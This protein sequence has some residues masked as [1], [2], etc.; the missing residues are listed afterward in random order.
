MINEVLNVK[1][2]KD[3]MVCKKCYLLLLTLEWLLA[4]AYGWILI[5]SNLRISDLHLF[6]VYCIISINIF[7]ILFPTFLLLFLQSLFSSNSL[8]VCIVIFFFLL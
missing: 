1:C 5:S 6:I 3:C 2:L 7:S 4:T 8:D